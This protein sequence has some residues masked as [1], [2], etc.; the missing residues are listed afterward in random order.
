LSNLYNTILLT[1]ALLIFPAFVPEAGAQI[2][3]LYLHLDSTTFTSQKHSSAIKTV[4]GN[5]MKVDIDMIQSLPKI[6]GNTDPVNFIRNLPGV[7]TNSEYDSGIHINGCDNAQNSIRIGNVP[8]YSVNHLFGFFSVFNS[9]HYDRMQFSTSAK[10]TNRIGGELVMELADTLE[11]KVTGDVSVGMMSSQGTLGLRLGGHSHL[12]LS[13]RQSYINLLYKPWL[14]IQGSPINYKFG[15]YN[16]SWLYAKGRNKIWV[17]GYYGKDA[18]NISE[19]SF[20]VELMAKWANSM[21]A[22]H[23]EHQGTE[24]RHKHSIYYSGFTSDSGVSQNNSHV[25]LSSYIHSV[26][27]QGDLRWKDFHFG[28]MSTYYDIQPQS[29]TLN[30]IYG[31]EN[32]TTIKQNGLESFVE[33]EYRKAFGY[34]WEVEAGLRGNMFISPEKEFFWSASPRASATYNAYRAGKITASYRLS[35]QHIFQSGLSNIGLPIEFW[36]IAGKYSKPQLSHD[37]DLSYKGEFLNGALAVT[38]SAYYKQMYNQVEYF[39]DLLD[40]FTT[41][42]ELDSH[43]LKGRGWNYG[44]NMMVHKQTGD[45]TGWVSYALGRALRK[46]NHP[47]HTGIYPANHERIH[48]LNIVGSYRFRKWDFA[49]TFVC[50]SGTPFTAPDYYYLSSGQLITQYGEHNACRMRP[51]I[52]LDFS[53]TYSFRKDEKQENGINLSIYNVTARSNDV[54][55][56]LTAR[57][58]TYTYGPMSFFL[59][60]VP[61][62]SYFHKF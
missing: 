45:F 48:E 47:E 4:E 20:G 15:D 40:L 59:K 8:I 33:A 41:V 22:F 43:L 50:A 35:R 51:Y 2:D 53:A 32:F 3:S 39:G 13:A 6:L 56:R 36:F 16:L 9:T 24:T 37:F 21:G 14:K 55:Y 38:T 31:S 23:W 46:F 28:L 25:N 57:D 58:G 42:Y 12:R 26:G 17:D 10:G 7:Q 30:G 52:R 18:A 44:I 61:S 1:F 19:R 27:Y 5:I 62:V 34:N 60:L 11:R 29:P 54:M 49:G